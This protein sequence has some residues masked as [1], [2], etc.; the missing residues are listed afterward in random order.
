MQIQQTQFNLDKMSIS[1]KLTVI[2]EIWDNL[3]QESASIPSPAWHKDV[4]SARS[5]RVNAGI[6]QFRNLGSVKQELQSKFK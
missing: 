3:L 1:E 5:A 4:L 2:N 6:S